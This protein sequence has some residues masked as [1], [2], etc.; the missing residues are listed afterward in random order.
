MDHPGIIHRLP[1]QQQQQQQQHAVRIN[2]LFMTRQPVF[3]QQQQ[4]QYPIPSYNHQ[5]QH[6]LQQPIPP[7]QPVIS[8]LQNATP[9]RGSVASLVSTGSE[10]ES[11]DAPK[12]ADSSAPVS[13]ATSKESHKMA[14]R[15]RR[16]KMNE[17]FDDLKNLL[18]PAV[19]ADSKASKLDILAKTI[20][21]LTQQ[22]RQ[23][24]VAEEKN[25]A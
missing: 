1:Q 4:V 22:Q 17:L 11:D 19:F 6:P 15:A 21:F 16:T 13:F 14:E 5:Q 25:D 9:R 23:A 7:Q 8:S 3:L 12:P 24:T 20:E 2:P 18:P 10:S